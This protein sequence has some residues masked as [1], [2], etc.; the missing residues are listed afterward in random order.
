M[1]FQTES[2]RNSI[3]AIV[4]VMNEAGSEVG[5][6]HLPKDISDADLSKAERHIQNLYQSAYN[7]GERHGIEYVRQIMRKAIGL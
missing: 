6:V 1:N 5:Y 3:I 7:A 2:R 4:K